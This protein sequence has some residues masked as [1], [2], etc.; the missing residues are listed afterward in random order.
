[1]VNEI[2]NPKSKTPA[3]HCQSS[4]TDAAGMAIG[5]SRPLLNHL[6][7][8]IPFC[9][10]TARIGTLTPIIFAVFAAARRN[11]GLPSTYRKLDIPA[12][13]PVMVVTNALRTTSR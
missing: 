7:P 12:N 5:I 11:A 2:I 8:W 1:M 13:S 9:R 3:I 6:P 10:D 4:T